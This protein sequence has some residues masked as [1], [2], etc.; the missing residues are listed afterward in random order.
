M[1]CF[2]IGKLLLIDLLSKTP[3]LAF[4]DITTKMH[5]ANIYLPCFN[6]CSCSTSAVNCRNEHEKCEKGRIC[7]E[8]L[9]NKTNLQ[10]VSSQESGSSEPTRLSKETE[11]LYPHT[12]KD[13]ISYSIKENAQDDQ[14]SSLHGTQ[15]Q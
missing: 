10:N 4:V 1:H 8:D 2:T 3:H 13:T 9:K 6:W 15:M 7:L 5:L 14:N 12:E 11:L